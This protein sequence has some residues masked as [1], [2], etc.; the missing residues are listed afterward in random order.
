M[1]VN[2]WMKNSEDFQQHEQGLAAQELFRKHA[3]CFYE[4]ALHMDNPFADGSSE[5]LALDSHNCVSEDVV[6]RVQN[7]K[8]VGLSQ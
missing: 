3:K 6:H 2:L 4:T 7:I 1:S 5:L 8:S